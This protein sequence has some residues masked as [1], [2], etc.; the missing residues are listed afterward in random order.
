MGGDVEPEE[1][2]S[3]GS[4]TVKT[5]QNGRRRNLRT[6]KCTFNGTT[7]S[8]GAGILR[9]S[10]LFA[11]PLVASGQLVPVLERHWPEIPLHAVHAGPQPATA[12]VRA[13]VELAREA[14]AR[15]SNQTA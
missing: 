10:T 7:D 3:K 12:K 1:R 13:F 9:T 14:I 2:K 11:A 5:E 15:L 4:R 6:A 8:L